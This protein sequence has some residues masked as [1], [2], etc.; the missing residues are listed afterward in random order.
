MYQHDKE[1]TL[2]V[3]NIAQVLTKTL[4]SRRISPIYAFYMLNGIDKKGKGAVNSYDAIES[5]D[6]MSHGSMDS[7]DKLMIFLLYSLVDHSP[8]SDPLPAQLHAT[9]GDIIISDSKCTSTESCEI[10]NDK[11]QKR[12]HHNSWR[13]DWSCCYSLASYFTLALVS[14]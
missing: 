4:Y 14:L 10:V 7:S 1:A 6:C 12:R 5:N 3:F 2:S 13:S 9:K 11:S 8:T